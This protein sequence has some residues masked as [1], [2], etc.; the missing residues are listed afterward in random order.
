[1]DQ[2][3]SKKICRICEYLIRNR[4]FWPN[5][6]EMYFFD[7]LDCGTSALFLEHFYRNDGRQVGM[8]VVLP[9]FV[10]VSRAAACMLSET[11]TPDPTPSS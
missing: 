4:P 2:E 1:M 11:H 3:Y 7:C 5:T 8:Q 6:L 9:S 10:I